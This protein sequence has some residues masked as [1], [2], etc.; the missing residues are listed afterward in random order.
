[1]LC[2]CMPLLIFF[3]YLY[4]MKMMCC[5]LFCF[6]CSLLFIFTLFFFSFQYKEEKK[7]VL[8]S[9]CA[10]IICSI[11]LT[12]IELYSLKKQTITILC[13]CYREATCVSNNYGLHFDPQI[14]FLFICPCTPFCPIWLSQLV[15]ASLQSS[16]VLRD[17]Y[18]FKIYFFI[19]IIF[20]MR[21]SSQSYF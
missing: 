15:H 11:K 19:S 5:D 14:P 17:T 12:W 6:V 9:F 2:G 3:Y 4:F 7:E 18:F 20:W 16:L 10:I 1:M 21:S 13:Y 8:T